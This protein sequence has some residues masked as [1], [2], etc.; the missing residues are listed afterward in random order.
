VDSKFLDNSVI[1][2]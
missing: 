1:F 2:N